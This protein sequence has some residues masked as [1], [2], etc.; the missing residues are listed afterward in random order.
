MI[1]DADLG[2]TRAFGAVE[3]GKAHPRPAT[4]V[5]APDRKVLWR[6]VGANASDRP[7]SDEI[8]SAL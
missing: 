6:H 1:A 2:I 4:Y 8:L 3:P 5:L 7:S